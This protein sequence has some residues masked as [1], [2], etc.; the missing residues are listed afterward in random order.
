MHRQSILSLLKQVALAA[1]KEWV[2]AGV[3]DVTSQAITGLKAP[4]W[5]NEC[6]IVRVLLLGRDTVTTATLV[7]ESV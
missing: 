7:K 5:K 3:A 4:V 2:I 1:K 6:F